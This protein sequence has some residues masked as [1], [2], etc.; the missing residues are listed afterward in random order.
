MALPSP[1]Q[2]ANCD[3]EHAHQV[4]VFSWAA[5]NECRYPELRWLHA[6][7]NGG[8]RGDDA[9]SS[10][11]VGAYMK[12][13]GVRSGILDIC[14]PVARGGFFGFYLELKKPGR[15]GKLSKEQKA[16]TAFLKSEN[17]AAMDCAHWKTAIEYIE[18]YLQ[19]PKTGA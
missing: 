10:A 6:I 4:A 2:L 3:S 16:F 17:Y 1:E 9:H 18:W 5:K 8:A 11:K 19:Q 7:P 13:E 14:L 12:A 15:Q